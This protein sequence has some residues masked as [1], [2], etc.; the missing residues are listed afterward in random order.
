MKRNINVTFRF[1]YNST[2]S[3]WKPSYKDQVIDLI[4]VVN[5]NPNF[6]TLKRVVLS[7]DGGIETPISPMQ[8]G[9]PTANLT[10]TFQFCSE[11]PNVSYCATQGKCTVADRVRLSETSFPGELAIRLQAR[12]RILDIV[13]ARAIV[14]EALKQAMYDKYSVAPE[15][16]KKITKRKATK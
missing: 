9:S 14:D 16:K 6:G 3:D 2:G 4:K 12:Y 11:C 1:E 10:K 15:A 13:T 8:E 5:A 7:V